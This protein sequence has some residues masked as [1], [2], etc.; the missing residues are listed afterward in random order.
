[1]L[2]QFRGDHDRLRVMMRDYTD[3]MAGD[4]PDIRI[5]LQRRRDF[6]SLFHAHHMGEGEALQ[7]V[8]AS[9]PDA[10]IVQV[11]DLYGRRKRD[12]FLRHSALVQQWPPHRIA[13]QWP[14]YCAAVRSE[15]SAFMDFLDWEEAIIHPILARAASPSASARPRPFLAGGGAAAALGQG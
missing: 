14:L 8:R 12:F 1:M 7:R 5:I 15:K 13:D 4:P 10:G 9:Q 11:L 2:A 6:S 3:L